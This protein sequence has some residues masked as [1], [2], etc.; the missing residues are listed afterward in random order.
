[1]I[2]FSHSLLLLVAAARKRPAV[3]GIPALVAP[4]LVSNSPTS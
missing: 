1:M 2:L 3:V 4:V